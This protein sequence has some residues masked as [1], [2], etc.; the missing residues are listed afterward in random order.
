[1]NAIMLGTATLILFVGM[2]DD[3]RSRK[4]HNE[5]F[6]ICTGIA[7]AAAISV[8]GWAGLNHALLGFLAGLVFM[9]PFVLMKIVGAGDMK[10]LAAFGAAAGWNLTLDVALASMVWGALF[11]VMQV[12]LKGQL[13]QMLRN[14]VVIAQSRGAETVSLHR[15]PFTVAFVFA[16]LTIL[17]QRRVL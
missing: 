3:L 15:L 10:L 17:V 7:T 4:F 2:A 11:G 12:T 8:N 6:L 14:M 5:L 9:L 13:K 1:M 16:W